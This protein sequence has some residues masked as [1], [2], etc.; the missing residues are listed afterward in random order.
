MLIKT[1]QNKKQQKTNIN[2]VCWKKLNRHAISQ[3]LGP[4]VTFALCS[5]SLMLLTNTIFI[6]TIVTL[7]SKR[8]EGNMF[9]LLM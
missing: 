5:F 9:I 2:N 7:L 1:K 3:N 4:F 6:V 8:N